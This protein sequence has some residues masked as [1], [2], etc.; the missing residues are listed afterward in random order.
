MAG[1]PG[2]GKM[3]ELAE[4]M[5]KA[6]Q[7]QEG[8]KQLQE[9]LEK[10][11]IVG[12]AG[13]GVV[14]VVMTGNQEPLRVEISQAAYDEGHEVL[15]DLVSAAMKDA[16]IKSTTTMREQMEALTEGLNIPGLGGM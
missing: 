12:E 4:A 13:G 9:D 16:Y 1:L 7:V 6:Q 15:S 14:K 11:E 2:L 3:K 5:K 8:A 10:M